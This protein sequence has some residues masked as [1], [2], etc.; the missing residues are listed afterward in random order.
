MYL[1][2]M[3]VADDRSIVQGLRFRSKQ[4]AEAA[5]SGL[6]EGTNDVVTIESDTGDSLTIRRDA[7]ADSHLATEAPPPLARGVRA[8]PND[9]IERLGQPIYNGQNTF[10]FIIGQPRY[11]VRFSNKRDHVMVWECGGDTHRNQCTAECYSE[12]ECIYMPCAIHRGD[13]LFC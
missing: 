2:I 7:V 6:R 5:L 10:G 1:V 3:L 12:T 9:L 11:S 13:P 8:N 4:A